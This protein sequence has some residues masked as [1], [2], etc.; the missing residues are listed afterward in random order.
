VRKKSFRIIA[1]L[2]ASFFIV[3]FIGMACTNELKA[4]SDEDDESDYPLIVEQLAEKLDLEPEEV[5]KAFEDINKERKEEF[6]KG[7]GHKLDGAVEEG[8]ITKE[9]KDALVAKKEEVS[10]Q[11]QQIKDLPPDERKEALKDIADDLK[12]WAEENDIQFKHLFP[13]AGM[14]LMRTRRSI[15]RHILRFFTK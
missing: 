13:V 15:F 6:Q 9:Q 5:F 12:E 1:V 14:K 8:Y 11:L 7:F 10:E 3:S 2:A 4:A